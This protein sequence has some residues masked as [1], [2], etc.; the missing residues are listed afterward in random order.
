M[1][2]NGKLK[3]FIGTYECLHRRIVTI[4]MVYTE[5][6]EAKLSLIV[7]VLYMSCR[8]GSDGLLR[9]QIGLLLRLRDEEEQNFVVSG[10]GFLPRQHCFSGVAP[11]QVFASFRI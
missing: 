5:L 11:W 4:S 10:A 6:R 8:I 1:P 7:I 2:D 3:T 9:G